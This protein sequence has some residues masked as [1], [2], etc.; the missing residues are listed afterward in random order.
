MDDDNTPDESLAFPPGEK[1]AG[2]ALN[3]GGILGKEGDTLL[4][5][6]HF[7][8]LL[9]EH[10]GFADLPLRGGHTLKGF[11]KA[12]GCGAQFFCRRA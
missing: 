4:L 5:K 1:D 12:F 7:G 6:G 9:Q 3:F 11:E 2:Q 10:P 8:G